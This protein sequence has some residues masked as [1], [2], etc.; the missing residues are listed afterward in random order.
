MQRL[1]IVIAFAVVLLLS[2]CTGK[3]V[4]VEPVKNFELDAYLG[5]WYEIARLDHSFE[6]GLSQV[7]AQYSLRD[8]GGVDV[9]NQGYNAESGDWKTANGK[10]YFVN[11][12]DEGFL[13]VSF[14]GPF[15]GSY[16]VFDTDYT[17]YAFVSGPN[18][19]YLWFLS[20]TPTVSPELFE[21]FKAQAKQLGFDTTQLIEVSQP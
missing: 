15:F 21:R 18:T 1:R 2:A 11:E 8:D 13:K 12:S 20:R 19:G 7:T 10:A 5:T 3:P 9:L 14:F 4:G 16:I 17:Q 6:R